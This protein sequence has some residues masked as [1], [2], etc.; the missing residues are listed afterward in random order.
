M[1]RLIDITIDIIFFSINRKNHFDQS[2]LAISMTVLLGEA[3]LS[4]AY[5]RLFGTHMS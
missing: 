1:F 3:S 2:I 4:K 5:L